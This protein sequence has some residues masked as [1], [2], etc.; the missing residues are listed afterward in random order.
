M[1]VGEVGEEG[2]PLDER[3]VLALK[4]VQAEG[5]DPGEPR[6]GEDGV[7]VLALLNDGRRPE[8]C[9]GG[10]A[11]P[12]RPAPYPSRQQGVQDLASICLLLIQRH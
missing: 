5:G 7:E 11:I 4:R 9:L 2:P 10:H 6:D 8:L 1:K 12:L 3:D